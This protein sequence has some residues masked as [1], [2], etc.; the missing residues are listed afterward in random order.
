M[1][2]KS[3]RDRIY[4]A[5]VEGDSASIGDAVTAA[6]DSGETPLPI[7]N[8]VLNPALKDV[9][10]RFDRGDFFLPELIL[11]AEAM[12]AAVKV[13]QPHLDARKEQIQSPGRVL[14]ATVQG[15]I[16]DIGKNIVTALLRANG[17]EVLDLGKDVHAAEILS[18]AE[19]F[20]ADIIGLSALLGTTLPY[21]RDTLRL[22]EEKGLRQKYHVFIGG[23][24]ATPDY[25]RQIG[26][27]Y[28]GAHA[29]A[30]V[31]SMRKVLGRG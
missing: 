18:K 7:I 17:F 26:A 12:Q 22:L 28:G 10:D 6:L 23:G 9:G 27:E 1:T 16:H 11:A 14:M 25:A 19:E 29:E 24:A 20:R 8:E 3:M 13:L 5:I 15:D 31:A 2:K 4:Q 30:A 21:C